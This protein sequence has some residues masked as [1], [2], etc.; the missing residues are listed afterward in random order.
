MHVLIVGF[1][2]M[3]S[4]ARAEA[5]SPCTIPELVAEALTNNPELKAAEADLQA[6]KGARLQAGLWKNPDVS[7]FYA[8]RQLRQTNDNGDGFS[9][10]LSITQ[11]FEFPGKATLRKAI[12]DQDVALGKI[13]LVQFRDALAGRVKLLAYRYALAGENRQAADLATARSRELIALLN[14]RPKAGLQA[15]FDSGVLEGNLAELAVTQHDF[16][17]EAETTLSELN[18]LRGWPARTPLRVVLPP[19]LPSLPDSLDRLLVAGMATSPILQMKEL[20]LKKAHLDV[21]AAQLAPAPDFAIGPFYS[22]D[23]AT[24]HDQKIGASLTVTLPIWNQNQ[25]NVMASRAGLDKTEATL[26]QARRDFEL[27]VTKIYQSR[28]LLDV[29]LKQ[30]NAGL[31]QRLSHLSD[32]AD[33][34]YRLGAINLTTFLEVQTQFLNANRNVHQAM[35]DAV[36]LE[37]DL[38]LLTG[39]MSIGP[40][41]EGVSR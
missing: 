11:T 3:L 16:A 13:G 4:S 36:S 12:A 29:E 10:Q 25:G 17:L 2:L 32:M 35:L 34:Q 15:M 40:A 21:K 18:I 14:K 31:L 19:D 9:D 41:T 39:T 23:K 27:S 5:A 37:L 24:D 1:S 20:D 33:R 22:L 38:Q 8:W 7:G 26:E 30:S 28:Q 6:A